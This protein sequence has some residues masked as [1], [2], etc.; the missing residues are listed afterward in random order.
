ML[1]LVLRFHWHSVYK[2]LSKIGFPCGIELSLN[3]ASLT[4]THY[5]G[6]GQ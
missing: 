6:K 2:E 5:S 1:I 3:D 4:Q